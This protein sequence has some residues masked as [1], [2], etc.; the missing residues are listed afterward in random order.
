MTAKGYTATT[1]DE[2][3]E[4]AG[5]T[6]GTFFHYFSSKEE[7]A[8]A[9]LES[10]CNASRETLRSAPFFRDAD[11]LRRFSGFIDFVAGSTSDPVAQGC[12]A[13]IFAQELSE[14]HP[15]LR[16]LCVG[17]FA[18]LRSEILE[19]LSAI[20]AVH[21]PD[22]P[23]DPAELAD[24]FLAVFEGAFVMAR[25]HR[26]T[27]PLAASLRHYEQY[28]RSLF[29]LGAAT[30]RRTVARQAPRRRATTSRRA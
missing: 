30:R 3:C 2:I 7:I 26:S 12:L 25:A 17:A 16:R 5:V 24:H 1:V 9:A 11:P 27:A 15:K 14:T 29:T 4:A 13:G 20:K 8:A 21:A 6:K 19:L 10:Y 22:A 23:H 28:V 18:Q